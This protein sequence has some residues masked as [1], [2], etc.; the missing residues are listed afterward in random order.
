MKSEPTVKLA[1]PRPGA[2]KVVP[3]MFSVDLPVS[4]NTSL[5]ESPFRRLTP[6]NDASR[7][8]VVICDR[9]LLN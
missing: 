1:R 8:V 7:E 3:V 2:S 4:L 5:S 6:L 9:M